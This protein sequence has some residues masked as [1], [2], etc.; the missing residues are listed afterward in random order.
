[1]NKSQPITIICTINHKTGEVTNRV[2]NQE[3]LEPGFYNAT[4]IVIDENGFSKDHLSKPEVNEL[5]SNSL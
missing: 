2:I 1:M 3:K 5:G 4:V